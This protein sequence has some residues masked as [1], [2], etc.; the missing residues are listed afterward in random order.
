MTA[1]GEETVK[2]AEFTAINKLIIV[3]LRFGNFPE[4]KGAAK[5]KIA[6]VSIRP[7]TMQHI[8]TANILC[9]Y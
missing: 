8:Q 1:N 5:L 2:T 4:M 6:Y 3:M 7:E 9:S